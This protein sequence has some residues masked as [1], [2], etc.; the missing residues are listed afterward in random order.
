MLEILVEGKVFLYEW[1]KLILNSGRF[2]RFWK[3]PSTDGPA[4]CEC[5]PTLFEICQDQD[6]SVKDFV[7]MQHV[8]PFRWRL[9]YEPLEEWDGILLDFNKLNLNNFPNGV[10]WSLGKSFKFSTKSVYQYMEK[11]ISRTHNKW[12]WKTNIPLKIKKIM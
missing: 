5:F 2:V 7:N 9:H 3:D 10:T 1:E 6:F 4:L 12:I 11:D 8:L